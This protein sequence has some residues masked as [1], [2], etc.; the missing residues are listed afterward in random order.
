MIKYILILFLLILSCEKIKQP[1]NNG[2]IEYSPEGRC[3][4]CLDG[5][6]PKYTCSGFLGFETPCTERNDKLKSVECEPWP[7]GCSEMF[8]SGVCKKCYKGFV[9]NKNK[10]CV[11]RP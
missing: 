6:Y 7:T 4:K 11:G 8:G 10:E 1:A 3:E 5:Y 9:F 2:C